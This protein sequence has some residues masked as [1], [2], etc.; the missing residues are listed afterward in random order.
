MSLQAIALGLRTHGMGGFDEAKARA[1]FEIPEDFEIGAVWA[2]GYLGDPAV[3]P[4]PMQ[5]ME[6]APRQRKPLSEFVF[7]EWD[8]AAE[9]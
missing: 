2:L 7:A 8:K 4:D 9:L 3:L 1:A 5:A 6:K